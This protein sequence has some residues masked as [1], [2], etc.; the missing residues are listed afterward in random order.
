MNNGF[1][2]EVEFDFGPF[3]ELLRQKGIGMKDLVAED[4][5]SAAVLH[6]MMRNEN[7]TVA[8]LACL[9]KRLGVKDVGKI[10]KLFIAHRA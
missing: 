1:V 5:I 7:I 2:N 4:T 10:V 8:T 9:M 3:F 6:R